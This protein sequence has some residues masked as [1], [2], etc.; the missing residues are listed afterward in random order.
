[1]TTRTFESLKLASEYVLPSTAGSAKSGAGDPIASGAGW[2][3]SAPSGAAPTAAPG[4]RGRQTAASREST[5]TD[6]HRQAG[7][8]ICGVPLSAPRARIMPQVPVYSHRNTF[9]DNAVQTM[10]TSASA[11][12]S[13]ACA[14]QASP[15]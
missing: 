6:N 15:R 3:S 1:M 10:Y 14:D 11:A 12:T 7:L 5:E 4:G 2:P 9:A 13:P 8:D